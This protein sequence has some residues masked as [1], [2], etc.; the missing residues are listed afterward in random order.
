MVIF[1]R[2]LKKRIQSLEDHL[3]VYYQPEYESHEDSKWSSIEKIKDRLDK[4]EGKKK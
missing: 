3:G 1:N 2:K 4:V